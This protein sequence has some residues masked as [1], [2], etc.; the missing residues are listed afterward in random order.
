VHFV[1]INRKVE[2]TH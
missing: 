2:V 1:T